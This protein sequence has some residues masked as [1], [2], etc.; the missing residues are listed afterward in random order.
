MIPE[1]KERVSI[2]LSFEE[3]QKIEDLI[4]NK[5]Y[6]TISEIIRIAIKEFLETKIDS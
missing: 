5:D 4:I 2:R 1:Y 3:R 6:K